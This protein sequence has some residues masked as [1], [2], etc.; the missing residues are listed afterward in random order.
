M[1][2]SPLPSSRLIHRT[3]E[4]VERLRAEWQIRREVDVPGLVAGVRARLAGRL[5]LSPHSLPGD[6]THLRGRLGL[7]DLQ[8][9]AWSSPELRKCV[10]VEVKAWPII[11]GMALTLIPDPCR[12]APVLAAD[13]MVLPTRMSAN[14]EVYGPRELTRGVLAP[15]RSTFARLGWRPGPPWAAPVTSGEGL[16]ARVSLRH[17][18]ELFGAF[19]GALGT[20]LDHLGAAPIGVDQTAAQS[21]VFSLFHTHGP[22]ARALG[23]MVG[24]VPAE[25]LSRL[26]FE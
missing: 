5:E 11:E 7:G 3:I 1:A 9:T 16:H 17:V 12:Q 14:L 22:R 4:L 6:L 23:R 15:A 18:D 25:R 24:E 19:T 13:F 20:Y 26:L 8:A 10:L 2:R 21:R